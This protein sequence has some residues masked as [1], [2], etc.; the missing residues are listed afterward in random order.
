MLRFMWICAN[1]VPARLCNEQAH[2][3]CAKG[4]CNVCGL[5]GRRVE[6]RDVPDEIT[7]QT[8][9]PKAAAQSDTH[10]AQLDLL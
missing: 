10:R 1:C 4:A 5:Q 2:G 3:Y 9:T 6:W 8:S 7:A